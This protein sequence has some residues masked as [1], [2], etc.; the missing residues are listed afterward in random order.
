AR[1][2][3]RSLGDSLPLCSGSAGASLA[4]GQNADAWQFGVVPA[5][6]GGQVV[7]LALRATGRLSVVS[8]QLSP[9]TFCLLPVACCLLPFACWQ[10]TAGNSV[11]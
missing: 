4:R 2:E 10:M 1:R 6:C 8:C 9:V 5:R 3:P 7:T 11:G